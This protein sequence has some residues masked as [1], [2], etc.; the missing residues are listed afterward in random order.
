MN[1]HQRLALHTAARV[2][3]SMSMRHCGRSSLGLPET[4][5]SQCCRLVRKIDKAIQRGWHQAAR[6]L[7]RELV[8][9]IGT[10]RRRFEQAAMEL[11]AEEPHQ[12]IPTQRELFQ[13]LI[14]LE[15]EFDDVRLER[16]GPLS[17]VTEPVIL[18]DIDLGRFEIALDVDW[19]LRRTWGSYEVIALDPNPAASSQDTTHPHVQGNGLCEG[20]GRSAIR[21]ALQEGRLFDFFVLVRQILQTYNPTSAYV[22]LESW[23]GV[24]CRD[25][26]SQVGEGD[27]CFCGSCEV[28]TCSECSFS[29]AACGG[30]RCSECIATCPGCE[31][32]FCSRC[33]ESCAG[34]RKLFCQECLTDEKCSSCREGEEE[35]D[36][37]PENQAAVCPSSE[38]ENAYASLQPVRVGE[39]PVSS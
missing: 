5:W 38:A 8:S 18:D 37:E 11:D 32:Y 26:G 27:S 10:C 30:C 39:A 16:K 13:E 19:D 34:C 3:Q 6:R 21:R 25:C 1:D 33:L 14:A 12:R 31:D 9:A 20:D 17:V 2:Q 23:N 35:Q 15:D 24:E 7:R 22:T 36:E 28:D 29:C 4:A